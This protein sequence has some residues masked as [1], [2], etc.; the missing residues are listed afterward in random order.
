M[1]SK[2][3][4]GIKQAVA[5]FWKWE[6]WFIAFTQLFQV[7]VWLY[8]WSIKTCVN[9]IQRMVLFYIEEQQTIQLVTATR[10]IVAVLHETLILSFKSAVE[11]SN[12]IYKITPINPKAWLNE[13]IQASLNTI[14]IDGVYWQFFIY[15]CF[16]AHC[17]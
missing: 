12:K 11:Q 15:L 10:W 2:H 1:F 8:G 9:Q 5:A 7:S 17:C 13:P 4:D 3:S 6:F 16:N 14:H